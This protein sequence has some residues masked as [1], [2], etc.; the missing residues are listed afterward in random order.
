MLI[1]IAAIGTP[2]LYE[3]GSFWAYAAIPLVGFA[4]DEYERYVAETSLRFEQRTRHIFFVIAAV[5]YWFLALALLSFWSQNL[6][7]AVV[8]D[9]KNTSLLLNLLGIGIWTWLMRSLCEKSKTGI[10]Y[11]LHISIVCAFC[12]Q[13]WRMIGYDS[14]CISVGGDPLFGGGG[15]LI[16][17]GDF[18]K[19][20]DQ[21]KEVVEAH[22]FNIAA[23]HS[24]EFITRSC[25]MGIAT[26]LA[27]YYDT[28]WFNRA[29]RDRD[30]ADK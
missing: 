30:T 11:P 17:D 16:C 9:L 23:L 8:Y 18:V 1:L 26:M 15:E 10:F 12:Y 5:V 2:V 4:N 28:P 19:F 25:S 7:T 29:V 27:Y 14:G 6:L 3:R 22:K 20:S 13:I 24:A 21:T